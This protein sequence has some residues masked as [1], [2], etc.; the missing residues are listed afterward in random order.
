MGSYFCLC[1]TVVLQN[2]DLGQPCSSSRRTKLI[3]IMSADG[4]C[5]REEKPCLIPLPWQKNFWI[6]TSHC[7]YG[8]KNEDIDMYDFHECDCTQEQ[9]SNPYFS[10]IVRQPKWPSLSREI[11]EIQKFCQYGNVTL[12]FSSLLVYAFGVCLSGFK[13]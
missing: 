4:T 10:S 6:S 11:I 3:I 5:D 9:N 7:K 2:G 1:I 12:H 13:V 8:R